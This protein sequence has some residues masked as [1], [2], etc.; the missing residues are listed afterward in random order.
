MDGYS[1]GRDVF[2]W[3]SGDTEL[4]ALKDSG[5]RYR[6]ISETTRT[7]RTSRL[8]MVETRNESTTPETVDLGKW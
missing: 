6:D 5:L 8:M 4:A 7:F 1:N 3:T 2:P